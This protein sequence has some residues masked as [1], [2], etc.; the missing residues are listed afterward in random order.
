M[1]GREEARLMAPSTTS[2][3]AIGPTV[4]GLGA[5]LVSEHRLD[6]DNFRR[7]R[8]EAISIVRRARPFTATPGTQ[9][10]LVVGYVQSGKTMSMTTVACLAR[11]NGCRIIVLLAG[12]TTNLLRQ[13]TDRF[14]EDL[15]GAS[16]DP[17]TWLILSSEE[18]MQGSSNALL[19][20]QAVGEWRDKTFPPE[21]HRT[22]FIS[23]LK[24][25]AHLDWLAKLFEAERLGDIPALIF[26]DEADQAGL[27]VGDEETPSTTYLRIRR[28]RAALPNHTYLQYTATPQAPL[29][30]SIDDM[31]SPA[32]AELVEPGDGYTGGTTFFPV[33]EPHPHVVDIPLGDHFKPGQP[34]DAPPESLKHALATF[35][36]GCAL[37][38][39]GAQPAATAVRS[40][41]V[42]PSPRN[43]D[44]ERFLNWTQEIQGRW[45]GHLATEDDP[46]RSDVLE[47]LRAGHVELSRTATSL[48]PFDD[49]V[50]SL[51]IVLSRAK[52]KK[53]NSEDATE[54]DW[55][56]AAEHILVGGEKL[57]RGYTVKGLMV[58]YMPRDSGGWNA[59]TI[60]Q[61]A[62]FFGY[63]RKYLPLCRV[64]LHPDVH[65]AYSAYVVHEADVRRQLRDFSGRP[66]RDWKRAF[67]LDA[68]MKATRSNVLSQPMFRVNREKSWF[69]A[70]FPHADLEALRENK[71]TIDDVLQG[72][73]LSTGGP[74]KLAHVRS[75]QV[76]LGDL[77]DKLLLNLRMP[78]ESASWYAHLVTVA[79]H[80]SETPEA[81]ARVVL[82]EKG[83]AQPRERTPGPV[84]DG[85]VGALTLHQGRSEND[86]IG[87][88]DKDLHD[89]DVITVQLI[90]VKVK[91]TEEP[92]LQ[93]FWGVALY[94]K[95][96]ED[97]VGQGPGA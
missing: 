61:R 22:L 66:L 6:E 53:V 39:A 23:V 56:N 14:Q 17:E 47:E 69:V 63:K 82:L 86:K 40:M 46:D 32:F 70:R 74:G 18:A 31:L 35:F 97:A 45:R 77:L 3:T 29:L 34:P 48:P 90:R 41:L 13:N 73:Q 50:P 21:A 60:Q 36:V 79:N 92:W 20:K 71:R 76:N 43:S 84:A 67:F 37:L 54:V 28:I 2:T 83:P 64:Y 81:T 9:T 11:D 95:K 19:L 15:R 88:G 78:Q 87:A 89:P 93:D 80:R 27:N 59:D 4:E 1:N 33:R 16:D 42:H 68:A 55:K 49:L 10:G 51:K 57:N 5:H 65:R 75:A 62:R 7:V 91:G 94:V 72:L 24:N 26:D 8:D 85:E 25:H 52:A 96:H 38:R 44:Q 12:V 58:T 30:I